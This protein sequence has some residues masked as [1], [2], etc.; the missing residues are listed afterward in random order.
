MDERSNEDLQ[1]LAPPRYAF[2][3]AR[4]EAVARLQQAYVDGYLTDDELDVRLSRATDARTQEALDVL[5][6]GLPGHSAAPP[7]ALVPRS[8]TSTALVLASASP[9]RSLTTLFGES[10]EVLTLGEVPSVQMLAMFADMDL[11]FREV[12]LSQGG[13]TVLD[14]RVVVG[15]IKVRVPAGVRVVN[16]TLAILGEVGGLRKRGAP[17]PQDAT[18]TLI[19]RGLVL[20]GEVSIRAAG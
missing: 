6:V 2:E 17:A 20:F 3:Q 18:H 11:T 16:E 10:E 1:P 4:E 14:L 5:F 12:G 13:T 19:L 8:S 15:D 9:S 7:T